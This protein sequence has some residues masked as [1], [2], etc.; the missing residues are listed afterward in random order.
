MAQ[1]NQDIK[2]KILI[3]ALE[4]VPFDGWAWDVILD[5]AEK[6]GFDRT[7]AEAVF[8]DKVQSIL[9]HFSQW[10]DRAMMIALEGIDPEDLKIRDR[11]K[12]A[13]EKRIEILSPYKESVRAASAYWMHPFRKKTAAKHVW[14]TADYIWNWAGDTAE[15]YNHYTK[16]FLL[17]GVMTTTFLFWFQDKSESHE[18]TFQ[19]LDRRIENVLVIGKVTGRF[20]KFKF[21]FSSEK[22]KNKAT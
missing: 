5:A 14:K 8:P 10:A 20:K 19:F 6:A 16:R 17:S 7:M 18:K 22:T 2:D 15:D 3:A 4:D 1:D 21:P 13:V 12:T 9:S 11:V